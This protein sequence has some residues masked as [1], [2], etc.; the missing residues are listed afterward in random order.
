MKRDGDQ[1][2]VGKREKLYPAYVCRILFSVGMDPYLSHF[3]YKLKE[4]KGQYF[5]T[6]YLSSLG[7]RSFVKNSKWIGMDWVD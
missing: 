4:K 7:A 6:L 5:L 3:H 1:E 2:Q